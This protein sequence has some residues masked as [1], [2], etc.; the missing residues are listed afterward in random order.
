MNTTELDMVL[1]Q[2]IL[3]FALFGVLYIISFIV[4]KKNAHTY[5][6]EHPLKDRKTIVKNKKIIEMYLNSS[7]TKIN[8]KDATLVKLS[9]MFK[10]KLLTKDEFNVLKNSLNM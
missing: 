2:A 9:G 5:E 10:N 1:N 3:F 7:L 4:S 6:L 8:G